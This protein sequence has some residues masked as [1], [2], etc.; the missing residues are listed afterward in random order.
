MKVIFLQVHT[1]WFLIILPILWIF[2]RKFAKRPAIVVSN[3]GILRKIFGKIP[4]KTKIDFLLHCR[5]LEIFLL[6]LAC[7]EPM[8]MTEA[9]IVRGRWISITC[10][11]CLFLLE[12]LLKNTIFHKIP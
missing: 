9:S 1:M 8:V 2:H 10:S 4:K 3:T 5:L 6:V 11:F 12:I 7:A